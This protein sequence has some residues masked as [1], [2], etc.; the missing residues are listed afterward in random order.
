LSYG[1]C[2]VVLCLKAFDD[3]FYSVIALARFPDSSAPLSPM[4][5]GQK[6]PVNEFVIST[7]GKIF[8]TFYEF[9]KPWLLKNLMMLDR[10]YQL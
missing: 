3:S 1:A 10:L 9:I 7:R 4:A 6:I 5:S 2:K 8:R